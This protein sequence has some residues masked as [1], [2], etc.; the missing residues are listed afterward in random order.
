[1]H[2]SVRFILTLLSGLVLTSCATL[3]DFEKLE[4]PRYQTGGTKGAAFC[5]TC[6]PETH[7]QWSKYSR[8]AVAT[9]SESFKHALKEVRDNPVIGA[10]VT[11]EMCYSCHGN[12]HSDE[13][14]NCE[15]CHGA[16]LPGVDI[17]VTHEQKYT[18]RLKEMRKPDF[19]ARC[20]QVDMP[21]TG[22]PL[23]TLHA[24]WRK[25]PAASKG[26][27][28]QN[29]HMPKGEDDAFAFHGFRSAVRTPKLYNG[30]LLVRS[31]AHNAKRVRM[32]VVNTVLGH[33]IPASGTTRVLGLTL[34]LH[35]ADGKVVHRDNHRFFK[36]F[37][38]APVVGGVPFMLIDNTQLRAGEQ[39]QV[40]FDLPEGIYSRSAELFIE[41]RMYEVAEKYE[42]R[43]DKA[44]WRSQPIVQQSVKIADK[45][46]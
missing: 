32:T 22:A 43:I 2:Y 6:H 46:S 26:L 17:M 3:P 9:R 1:V 19:C 39:R 44:H 30:T 11:D 35:D 16:V 13:G 24:E 41:L 33:S 29:C 10:I 37:N 42:G 23:T 12:K 34:V 27:T 14:I 25:S 7:E 38:M 18:P 28:C 20:H 5:A 45:K 21:I 40:R 36:H 4:T 15:S 8:H 31:I